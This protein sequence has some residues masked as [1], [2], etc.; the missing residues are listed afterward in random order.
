MKLLKRVPVFVPFVLIVSSALLLPAA[1]SKQE[2]SRQS[3]EASSEPQAA[4]STQPADSTEPTGPSS[5]ERTLVFGEE[6][7]QAPRPAPQEKITLPSAVLRRNA[8]FLEHSGGRQRYP[9]DLVIGELAVYSPLDSDAREVRGLGRRFLQ[10][11]FAGR[12]EDVRQMS[13]VNVRDMLSTQIEAWNT[14]GVRMSEIRIGKFQ[15]EAAAARFDFRILAPPGRT[16]GS[17]VCIF[18]DEQWRV[19]AVECETSALQERYEP[20]EY[21][22]FPEN[23]GYFQY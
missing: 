21:S 11:A 6:S 19:Q 17:V 7:E 23:Y 16:A 14:R 15:W 9:I 8:D 10:A 1:C 2:G 22:D 12:I 3:G 13:S 20:A 18:E 4:V 5:P